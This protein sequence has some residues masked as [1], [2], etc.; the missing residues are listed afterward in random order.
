MAP[1]GEL[2]FTQ[3]GGYKQGQTP[4]STTLKSL[5]CI[6][7]V[8]VKR[9]FSTLSKPVQIAGA[10]A[11][12]E[13]K[14]G[15][16]ARVG[17]TK[18]DSIVIFCQDASGAGDLG[19]SPTVTLV[20]DPHL[21]GNEVWLGESLTARGNHVY[22]SQSKD[23]FEEAAQRWD[24]SF[25]TLEE[26]D[27]GADNCRFESTFPVDI[28]LE[29]GT[30]SKRGGVTDPLFP[31]G[32]TALYSTN[33]AMLQIRSM[34]PFTKPWPNHI[35]LD[36]CEEFFPRAFAMVL[37]F[38]TTAMLGPAK[39]VLVWFVRDEWFDSVRHTF[40]K[41][42]ALLCIGHE[43]WT[44]IVV[45]RNQSPKDIAA[46]FKIACADVVGTVL[47]HWGT[48]NTFIRQGYPLAASTFT[49]KWPAAER[50]EF[51]MQIINKYKQRYTEKLKNAHDKLKAGADLGEPDLGGTVD[52]MLEEVEPIQEDEGDLSGEES[53]HESEQEESEHEHEDL[54]PSEGDD[55]EDDD[56]YP[57]RSG[58]RG[59]SQPSPGEQSSAK[60]PRFPTPAK[61]TVSDAALPRRS[62]SSTADKSLMDSPSKHTRARGRG[63]GTGSL[64]ARKRRVG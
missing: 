2:V 26:G 1:K 35:R 23:I 64:G 28:T 59:A 5:K 9:F 14:E 57:P 61:P 21:L 6:N 19:Q 51:K 4:P 13:G 62:T 16:S 22:L 38:V 24:T 33:I 29:L 10:E 17:N 47:P 15:E 46:A 43:H 11:H 52:D 48:A 20:D 32:R 8:A 31:L 39:C 40:L 7:N 45:N 60:R 44:L 63:T 12:V 53:E 18:T 37:H 42:L 3:L 56:V 34:K 27:P 30:Q 25:D 55:E 41:I 50:R 58:K 49:T 36:S 54:T